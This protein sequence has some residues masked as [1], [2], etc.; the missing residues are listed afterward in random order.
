MVH[1]FFLLLT[2]VFLSKNVID[3]I[4][5]FDS[6]IQSTKD[7]FVNRCERNTKNGID[8]FTT[9]RFVISKKNLGQ[10]GLVTDNFTRDCAAIN[11]Y[12]IKINFKKI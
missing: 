9:N 8:L 4:S 11:I 7:N 1:F 5:I 2:L 6:L 3:F 10:D 12:D